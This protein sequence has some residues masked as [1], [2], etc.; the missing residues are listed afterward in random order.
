LIPLVVAEM[1]AVVTQVKEAGPYM[2]LSLFIPIMLRREIQ[3]LICLFLIKFL[4]LSLVK[5]LG[6]FPLM[7]KKKNIRIFP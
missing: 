7:I 6:I 2:V 5:N 1:L 4:H 3:R